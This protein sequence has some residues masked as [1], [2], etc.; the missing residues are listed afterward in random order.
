[1]VALS[2]LE[3][4]AS[5]TVKNS[6]DLIK[7]ILRDASKKDIAVIEAGDDKRSNQGLRGFICQI[8]SDGT[9]LSDFKECTLADLGHLFTH[10]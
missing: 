1:M 3:D 7:E 9:Y 10:R 4:K 6:L 2:S 8:F 5:C